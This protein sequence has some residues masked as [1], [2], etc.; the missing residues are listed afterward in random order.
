MLRI[1]DTSNNAFTLVKELQH[2]DKVISAKWHQHM[3]LITSTSSDKSIR[4]WLP[5]QQI[6]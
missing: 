5:G 3:P 6:Q 4:M 1:Y 2:N